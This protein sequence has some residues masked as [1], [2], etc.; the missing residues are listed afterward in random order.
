MKRLLKYQNKFFF[1]RFDNLILKLFSSKEIGWKIDFKI[2]LFAFAI[3]IFFAF[4][5]LFEG[6]GM[7]VI[8]AQGFGHPIV[9]SDI[10]VM[11][12]ITYGNAKLV[13]DYTSAKSWSQSLHEVLNDIE[14]YRLSENHKKATQHRYRY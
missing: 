11:R 4:P 14:N 5:S 8:E 2:A 10:E 3:T 1:K 12:E 6:F 13:K 9:V 7:P